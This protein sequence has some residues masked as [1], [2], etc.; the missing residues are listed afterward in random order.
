MNFH[1]SAMQYADVMKA[2]VDAAG[3]LV[4][5]VGNFKAGTV[6]SEAL[7]A[8]S[9]M[10]RSQVLC[11]LMSVEEAM[12]IP[13]VV[14]TLEDGVGYQGVVSSIAGFR[15]D[16]ESAKQLAEITASVLCE[17]ANAELANCMGEDFTAAQV[18]QVDGMWHVVADGGILG[19]VLVQKI[20]PARTSDS[21]E[22]FL[23]GASVK[24]RIASIAY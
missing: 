12:L 13:H 23:I 9:E 17:S 4:N 11:G 21:S 22:S 20:T 10:N 15:F 18:K 5:A 3:R 6:R 24:D 7:L 1:E 16:A 2:P 19:T 8:V 14:L